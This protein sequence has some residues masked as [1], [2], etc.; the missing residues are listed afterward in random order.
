MS[1]PLGAIAPASR[2]SGVARAPLVL[3]QI[4]QQTRL[5]IQTQGKQFHDLTPLVRDAVARSSVQT[6]LCV[7]F[8]CHTS[9]SLVI[10]ENADPDVLRD[11]E[12]CLARLAPEGA[13]YRHDDEG[14]DDMPAHLRT[15][16][17]HTSEQI[18]IA[19]GG[20]VL[21]TWQAVYL[22]EHRQ[23]GRKREVVVHI[24]GGKAVDLPEGRTTVQDSP[25]HSRQDQ[26]SRDTEQGGIRE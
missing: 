17:T 6:G 20:L 23:Y 11:L 15:A 10:Q 26:G 1:V 2:P 22:W 8:V 7:L 21:G 4:H 12:T 9:A 25:D 19:R 16:L 24:M 3:Q 13:A 5:S 14:P 18:P